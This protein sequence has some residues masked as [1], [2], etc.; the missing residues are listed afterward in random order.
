MEQRFSNEAEERESEIRGGAL[1]L[2][3]VRGEGGDGEHSDAS[4]NIT[5]TYTP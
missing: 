2:G 4:F 3:Q 5:C 1:S